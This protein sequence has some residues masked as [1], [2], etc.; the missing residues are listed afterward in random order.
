MAIATGSSP[1]ISNIPQR[2]CREAWRTQAGSTPPI[3][4]HT[5]LVDSSGAVLV[6]LDRRPPTHWLA[7]IV[8]GAPFGVGFVTLFLGTNAYL[9]DC[10]GRFSARALA[11]N[12]FM[13]SL[14]SGGFPLFVAQMYVKLGVPWETSLLGFITLLIA[15]V[16]WL[17]YRC[18]PGLRSRSK[19]HLWAVEL[20]ETE[21]NLV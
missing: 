13:R 17:L 6:R 18:G 2:L 7:C 4:H 10:Y 15:P 12:A 1:W 3:S 20:E 9:T 5:G 14:F 8:A 21:K 19:D 11:A 16:P